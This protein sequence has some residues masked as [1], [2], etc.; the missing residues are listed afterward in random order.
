MAQDSR[1]VVPPKALNAVYPVS[2]PLSKLYC[3]ELTNTR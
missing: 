1:P 3:T 2:V